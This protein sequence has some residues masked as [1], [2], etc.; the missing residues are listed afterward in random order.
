MDGYEQIRGTFK[1]FLISKSLPLCP[2]LET[3]IPFFSS[4]PSTRPFSSVTIQVSLASR[5]FMFP[6]LS[7]HINPSTSHVLRL[8]YTQA[9]YASLRLPQLDRCIRFPMA[10]AHVLRLKVDQI[11]IMQFGFTA[12][13]S[14][15][16]ERTKLCEAVRPV[17]L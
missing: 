7:L 9:V 16:A 2:D 13:A 14:R 11:L 8:H 12:A 17:R 15:T 6:L 1:S 4:C 10:V 5:S 3:T